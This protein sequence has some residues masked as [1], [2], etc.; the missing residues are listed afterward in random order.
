MSRQHRFSA[1]IRRHA[2]IVFV[3]NAGLQIRPQELLFHSLQIGQNVRQRI[4]GKL[5][6]GFSSAAVPLQNNA[7]DG[8]TDHRC[9]N[10]HLALFVDRLE[11]PFFKYE[12]MM[13]A[14]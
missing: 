7:M 3:E 6:G 10:F 8:S 14:R 4:I 5:L 11:I 1:P 2:E 13:A 12:K 9:D